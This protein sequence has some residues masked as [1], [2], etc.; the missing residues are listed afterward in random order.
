[1]SKKKNKKIEETKL[2]DQELEDPS[3]DAQDEVDADELWDEV[4][5]EIEEEGQLSVDVY[6]DKNYVIIKST[7]AGVEPEDIDISVDNDMIT[8]RGRREQDRSIQEDDY[9]YQECYWGGFS[10]SI[11]LPVEIVAD[12]IDATIKNGILTVKL[13]KAKKN[14]VN[15]KVKDEN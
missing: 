4:E 15:I 12:E 10:R 6:Q 11:I 3:A 5:S 14:D 13:P 8:L 1:M 9:F 7:I 2:D